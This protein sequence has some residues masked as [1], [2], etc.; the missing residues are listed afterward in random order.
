MRIF[1][2]EIYLLGCKNTDFSLIKNSI[3]VAFFEYNSNGYDISRYCA[4]T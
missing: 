1:L 3:F 2:Y 4:H